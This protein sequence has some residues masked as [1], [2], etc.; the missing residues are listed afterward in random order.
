[1]VERGE[2]V[3]GVGDGGA[4]GDLGREEGEAKEK[5]RAGTGE[6]GREEGEMAG[7]GEEREE[8]DEGRTVS[9][10]GVRDGEGEGE[11]EGEGGGEREGGGE[12]ERVGEEGVRGE[13]EWGSVLLFLRGGG[14][15]SGAKIIFA[16]REGSQQR[17]MTWW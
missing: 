4:G 14:F 12:G 9:E 7:A 6:T 8:P 1:M 17:P 13:L 10:E 11:G 3:V 16:S 5:E 15:S 2:A